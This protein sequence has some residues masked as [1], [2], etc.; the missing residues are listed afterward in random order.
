MSRSEGMFL[1]LRG[2]GMHGEGLGNYLVSVFGRVNTGYG[3]GTLVG[4]AGGEKDVTSMG[5]E[6]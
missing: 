2:G 3:G 6:G 1:I 5:L 4:L